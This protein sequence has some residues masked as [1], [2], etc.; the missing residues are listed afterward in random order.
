MAFWSPNTLKKDG[1]DLEPYILEVKGIEKN[2]PGVKALDGVDLKIH[3]GEVHA[4][5]GENGAGKSTLMQ[6]LSGILKPCAGDIFVEGEKVNFSSSHDANSKGISIV[7]QELSL[8]QTLTVA[9]NIF[10]NRQPIK[11]FNLID[12]D[13]LY[14]D[15]KEMLKRFDIDHIKPEMLVKE[16]SVANQQVVEI[17][18]AMSFNPKILILDE[19]TSSLTEVEVKKLFENIIKMKAMGITF[20]YISHHLQEI[21]EIAD[22]V[23]ILRDG[24]YVTDAK[25]ADIDEDFLV[26]HMVG[27]EISNMYGHRSDDHVIGAPVFEV[28]SVGRKGAFENISFDVKAGEIV[29]FAGLVGAGRTE[30]GRAIFGAESIDSGEIFLEDKKVVI[31]RTKDAID[32]GIG[33]MSEDR[34]KDGLYLNFSIRDNFVSNKLKEFVKGIFLKDGRMND[35]STKSIDTYG[36]ITP[37]FTRAVANLSGGNQQKVMLGTWCDIKPKVLIVDEPTKGVDIGA[38]SEIYRQ[39][40]Q[41]ASTGVAV[42]VISSDLMEVLGI[43][44][45]IMVMRT[46]E[47]VKII[48]KEEATEENVIAYAAGIKSKE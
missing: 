46:G 15:T 9:E 34:K 2:F 45:R 30:L 10:A 29:S 8:I 13:K 23:T 37:D 38:K 21:F 28:K 24:Q 40:R 27:R 39:L 18:K 1:E 3:K 4:L 16:L 14:A 12:K 20:I 43:S 32:L 42:I 17:L 47:L 7:Y 6:T 31:S 35:Y 33:Y 26:K 25:V 19:P 44:D 11:G 5:I 22:W 48:D 36:V 41:L